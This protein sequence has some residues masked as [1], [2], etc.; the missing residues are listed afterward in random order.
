MSG[1]TQTFQQL[2]DRGLLEIGDGYRAQNAE[3]AMHGPGP[4]FLRAGH[5]TDTHIDFAGVER[6]VDAA[7][8]GLKSKMSRAGDAV[9]TTKGNSTGRVAF[10]TADMPP[11]VYSPHLSFW[12][13][14][15][16]HMLAPAF[17]RYWS[18]SEEFLAQLVGMSEST[19]MAPYLSLKDQ[20]SLKITVPAPSAQRI[21]ADTLEALDDK[22]DLNRRM[23]KTLEAM[24]AAIFQSWFVDFGPVVAKSEGR[25][26]FGMTPEAARVFSSSFVDSEAGPIPAGWRVGRLGEIA[27]VN[28]RS[29]GRDYPHK[30]ID[31]VDIASVTRGRLEASTPYTL[32]A[33]PSRA[34]RMVEHGDTIWS[35][36]RPNRRS[37]LLIQDP[38]E[39]RVVSTGFAVLSPR[40]KHSAYL[41]TSVTT[42][43][44]VDYLTVNAEG[45]AYP[46]VRPETFERAPIFVP[47]SAVLDAFECA[48]GDMLALCARNDQ[49]SRTLAALRDT[50][51]PGLLSGEIRLR[52]AEKAVG[53][54]V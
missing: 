13:S 5:V 7:T 26:P 11:F 20:R 28:R 39:N 46:A 42:D 53:Q 27:H 40:S 2:I 49:Q 9:I 23:N 44:F 18:R 3:L 6:F 34:K 32:S 50:L 41:Y 31:Y 17:L 15:N 30:T 52:E 1:N 48:V 54:A 21:I 25:K 51:L 14:L 35:C 4:I 24:A 37:F 43:E 33:A 16:H 47:P 12:R 38:P 29:L 45:S 10:V 8:P 19:D 36:V 22:I